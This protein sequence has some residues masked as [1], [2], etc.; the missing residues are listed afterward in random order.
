MAAAL[1]VALSGPAQGQLYKWVD[2]DGK[3]QYS[4]QPPPADAKQMPAA[5]PSSTPSSAPPSTPALAP[6][7]SA[8][9]ALR[10]RPEEKAAVCLLLTIN[11]AQFACAFGMGKFCTLDE[12]VK[13]IGPEKTQVFAKDPRAD[14]NYEHRITIGKE[15]YSWS[16][17]PRKPGLTGFFYNGRR[18][19]Y[20]PDGP[21]S[22]RDRV[23]DDADC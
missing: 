9:P 11:S 19:Y 12:L 6:S 22:D 15:T 18:T 10:F 23:M 7:R 1:S 2:K 4:D 14:P 20:N 16:A 3:T 8:S 5:K 21:A 13:G 17:I